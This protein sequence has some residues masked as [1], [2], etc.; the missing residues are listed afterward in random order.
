MNGE[1]KLEEPAGLKIMTRNKSN[2]CIQS[3]EIVVK[4]LTSTWVWP[5]IQ[6]KQ[7]S[8]PGNFPKQKNAGRVGKELYS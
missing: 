4:P 6:N 3:R 2:G 7:L 8:I 5:N 1:L